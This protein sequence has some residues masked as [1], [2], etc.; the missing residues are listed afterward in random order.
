MNVIL[1]PWVRYTDFRGRSTRTEFWLFHIVFWI[2]FFVLGLM[3]IIA[4]VSGARGP[5]VVLWLLPCVFLTLAAIIPSLAVGVRRLH[6]S[7]QPGWLYAV[8]VAMWIIIPFVGPVGMIVAG[9]IPGTKGENKYGDDPRE[10][11]GMARRDVDRI[12]G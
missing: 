8:I 9:F 10:N 7:D 6:D 2:A 11:G 12:F 5:A 1:R 4:S 3:P